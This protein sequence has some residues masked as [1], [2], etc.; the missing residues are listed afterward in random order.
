MTDPSVKFSVFLCH[1][2]E[3]KPKVR[4]L[5]K[6]LR[7]DGFAP[8]LDEKELLPGQDWQFE[9]EKALRACQAIL[10][11][12][13]KI[14]VEK[15]GFV[16]REIRDARK[17]AEEKPEGT[18]FVIPVRLS[19]C[20]I[21]FSL[22]GLHWV[23]YPEH[24]GKL[25]AALNERKRSLEAKSHKAP[26]KTPAKTIRTGSIPADLPSG[27]YLPFPRNAF[28]TGRGEDLEKLKAALSG[29]GQPGVVIHQAI[30]GMGGVGKTQLAVEFAYRY[31]HLFHGVHWLDLAVPEAFEA[32]IALCGSEMRLPAWPPTQPE[33]VAATLKAWKQD[34]PRLL[35]LDNF[36]ELAFAHQALVR[37]RHSNLRLL[38]TSRRADWPGALGLTPL[39]L[40]E[41][42]PQESR[43]FLRNYLP[44]SR[45]ED[46]AL[47]GL[48]TRLGRL[49][50]ALELAGRY[51]ERQP[52]LT[53]AAYLAQLENPFEHKSMQN[54]KAEQKLPTGH[55]LS[56][57]QT[58]ARSWELVKEEKTQRLFIAC[59]YCAPNT[60]L[61]EALLAAALGDA[62][63]GSPSPECGECSAELEG[64]GLFKGGPS[65]H[66]LLAQFGRGLDAGRKSLA[67]FSEAL[68]RLAN[69]TNHEEDS[70]GN[71]SLSAPLL[72]HVREAAG[73]AESAGLPAAG[74]LWNSFGYHIRYLADYAGAKAAFERALKFFEK[75]LG[76]EHPNVATLVNNLGGVL[77]ELGDLAGAKAAYERALKIDEA[78]YGPEHPSVATDVNNL[79]SA[80][81]ELGDLAG[82]K[83]A[84]GRALKIDEAT[85][86]PEH[87]RVATDVNN[88]G[89]VLQDLGDLARAK[90][91]FERALKIDEATYGHEHP[92]VA[93]RVNNLGS[94]LQD[95]G[96][97]AGA[98]AAYRRALKIDEAAYGPEHPN[99][100]TDVNNL[101]GVLKEL[102]D[103][104]GA[105][106]AYGRAL[107]ID[108]AAYGPEHPKVAIRV[109]NLGG[110]LQDL[111][112]LA[113]AR[114][115]CERALKIFKQFLPPGHPNIEIVQGNLDRL[116]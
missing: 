51:L 56:L 86:G 44:E 80:L 91:A 102:G 68:A 110:V 75:H 20:D 111:G 10:L 84:Y 6:R 34:G 15:E 52:L 101:G 45:A 22:K 81:N 7:T 29:G 47:D 59:A 50:L 35:I 12:F 25:V 116:N 90:T 92:K 99:V 87:P 85:Y 113:G 37:L 104:A 109:N 5:Y 14:S 23:D 40:E 33:Q 96:D 82:A 76:E 21:P 83:A 94:V 95:L 1:A 17:I 38:I 16:Q 18:I 36:E 66:P 54:W 67:Q 4:K 88:L 106:A 43:D 60:M 62:G 61:P 27:S 9:I 28:F 112:D 114:A 2:S 11:C 97:L 103:L 100:A 26:R 48:A 65:L 46:A 3:D 63:A 78:A 70:T 49:P 41:F 53:V 32:Q 105:K 98:K 74:K 42:T 30:T 58:F 108:E 8:W 24:Y 115:A 73:H 13:S 69:Q 93:I 79:G 107:K 64:L 89:R 55:D 71:Y 72:P 57:L 19:K 31:G 77:K 39:A